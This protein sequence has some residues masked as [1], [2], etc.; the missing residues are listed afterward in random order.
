MTGRRTVLKAA[1]WSVPVIAVSVAVP[2]AAASTVRKPVHCER[3]TVKGQPWW[4]VV[5]DDGTTETLHNGDVMRD[6]ELKGLC[7]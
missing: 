2:L 5:F 4:L 7:K 1:A 6:R 3:L